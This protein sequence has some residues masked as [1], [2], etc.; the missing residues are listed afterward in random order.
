M[1]GFAL[2]FLDGA[3]DG[4]G[5]GCVLIGSRVLALD[6]KVAIQLCTLSLSLDQ[7][8]EPRAQNSVAGSG[9]LMEGRL[10][11][12]MAAALVAAWAAHSAGGLQG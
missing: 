8:D 5:V 3:G 6:L 2:G 10:D 9:I 1:L 4:G 12:G 7:W 11:R